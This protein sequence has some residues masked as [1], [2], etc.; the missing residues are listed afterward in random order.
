MS[1]TIFWFLLRQQ[2]PPKA[3]KDP[4]ATK[5]PKAAPKETKVPIP[6]VCKSSKAQQIDCVAM[7]LLAPYEPSKAVELLR[8]V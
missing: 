7:W 2:Q 5:A 4:T 8:F 3:T 1:Y 6:A